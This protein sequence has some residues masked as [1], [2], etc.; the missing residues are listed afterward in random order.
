M[1]GPPPKKGGEGNLPGKAGLTRKRGIGK[2]DLGVLKRKERRSSISLW[3]SRG[4]H[5]CTVQKKKKKKKIE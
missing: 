2:E 5:H 4:E 1:S 3:V